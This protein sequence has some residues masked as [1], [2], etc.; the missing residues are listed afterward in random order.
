MTLSSEVWIW[1]PTQPGYSSLGGGMLSSSGV[2]WGRGSRE[3]PGGRRTDLAA[4]LGDVRANGHDLIV[5]DVVLFYLA[6]DQRQV[7]PK[8]LAA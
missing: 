4:F 6:V 2:A 1:A 5:E 8:A 7:G 3:R